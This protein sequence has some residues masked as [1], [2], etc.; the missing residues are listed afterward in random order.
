[1]DDA[2]KRK[3]STLIMGSREAPG[4]DEAPTLA[5]DPSSRSASTSTPPMAQSAPSNRPP[6]GVRRTIRG[7]V[8]SSRPPP[9]TRSTPPTAAVMLDHAAYEPAASPEDSHAPEGEP[10][11]PPR[12]SP[13]AL[14][15]L[16]P[17]R[18]GSALSERIPSPAAPARS[19]PRA[20]LAAASLALALV[21]IT[22]LVALGF[23][24]RTAPSRVIA[25]PAATA[26]RA[27]V[28]LLYDGGVSR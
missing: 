27:N 18:G 12:W 4:F 7:S 20:P 10:P 22:L 16:P 2:S 19:A 26:P 3:G 1:M 17:T 8:P 14:P 28:S 24:R 9:P 5:R 13:Y 23:T 21:I 11:A 6:S 15:P 25:P